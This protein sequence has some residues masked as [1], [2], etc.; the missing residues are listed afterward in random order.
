M[1]GHIRRTRSDPQ[2]PNE[3]NS[4]SSVGSARDIA[5]RVCVAHKGLEH[6]AV[7]LDAMHVRFAPIN[8]T[9]L[10]QKEHAVRKRQVFRV[11]PPKRVTDVLRI[12]ESL[13]EVARDPWI[14]F[15]QRLFHD[16]RM[17]DRQLTGGSHK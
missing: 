3:G 5:L 14:A 13:R 17:G 7:W 8:S 16:D 2:A 1:S 15:G 10:F 6:F 11:G 12:D 9:L 4:S